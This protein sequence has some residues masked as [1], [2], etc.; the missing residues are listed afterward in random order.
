MRGCSAWDWMWKAMRSVS[1]GLAVV[2]LRGR[3]GVRREALMS[4]SGGK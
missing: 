2:N 4:M 3:R 1:S